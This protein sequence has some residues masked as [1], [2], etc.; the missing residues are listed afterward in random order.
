MIS[1]RSWW[2]TFFG[3][4]E[5]LAGQGDRKDRLERLS[6]SRMTKQWVRWLPFVVVAVQATLYLT[7]VLTL[8]QAAILL[9][10]LEALLA[11]VVL[12]EFLLLAR[13]Y[14]RSHQAGATRVEAFGDALEAVLPRPVA[15]LVRQEVRMLGA[16]IDGIRRR[17]DAAPGDR[18]LTYGGRLRGI[19]GFM[20]GI[21]IFELAI[22]EFL[23]PWT[24]LRWT[25]L[26][27]G[28]YGLIWVLGFAAS[29]YTRPHLLDSGRLRLRM[30]TYADITVPLGTV[31]QVG[32]GG[33]ASHQRD[34]E[35]GDGKL[36]VSVFGLSNMSLTFAEPVDVDCGKEG[37]HAVR[38]VRFYADDPKAATAAIREFSSQATA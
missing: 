30:T 14:R 15:F 4:A 21:T 17:R 38:V 37:R 28:V 13:A 8:A 12:G 29:A 22:V 32:G 26:I 23:V 6:F 3:M 18:L 7:G 10:A 31:S 1:R 34:V 36:A 16:L 19:L 33:I 11:V 25:L 2:S 9:L 35:V 20:I 5:K 24:W 27:L